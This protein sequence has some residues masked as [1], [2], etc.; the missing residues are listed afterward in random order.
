[1]DVTIIGKRKIL[2][3]KVFMSAL[4]RVNY[5]NIIISGVC[6][7]YPQIDFKVVNNRDMTVHA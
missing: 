6:T 7:S 1:M 5:F 4:L 2:N 3:I